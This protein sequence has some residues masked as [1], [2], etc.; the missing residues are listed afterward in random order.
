MSTTTKVGAIVIDRVTRNLIR[1]EIAKE[2][3]EATDV[4]AYGIRRRCDEPIAEDVL[5]EAHAAM[6]QLEFGHGLL[7]AIG[8]E[9]D[10]ERDRCELAASDE[11]VSS[12]RYLRGWVGGN[13][14]HA[15][16]MLKQ[17]E[18][19]VERD[20]F[21]GHSQRDSIAITSALVTRDESTVNVVDELLSELVAA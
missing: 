19:G 18:A 10:G 9:L 4:V 11:L 3:L 1:D 20:Y 21:P 14:D 2:M 16:E 6:R 15:R 5:A 7:Q 8:W 13:L 12:L 17:Q